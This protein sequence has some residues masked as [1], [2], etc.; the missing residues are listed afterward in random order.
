MPIVD[1]FEATHEIRHNA[2]CVVRPVI[3]AMTA[4]ALEGERE[5][6]LQ[7]GM[8]DY[9][10]K[11]VKIEMLAQT[12]KKWLPA[13]TL[14]PQTG[15][16]PLFTRRAPRAAFDSRDLRDSENDSV[17]HELLDGF[18]DLQ[19]PNEPN[20][21]TELIDLFVEDADKRIEAIKQAAERNDW[22]T[23]KEQAHGLKGSSGNIGANRIHELSNRLTEIAN[24][25]SAPKS[26]ATQLSGKRMERLVADLRAEFEKV[27]RILTARRV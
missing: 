8:D 26:A 1:G 3:V 2:A 10:S 9:V 23:I 22:H 19:Q 11:P 13:A 6:C 4:H 25:N 16:L 20:I 21:V 5:K 18:K 12:L 27:R 7:A 15:E 17:N 14:A 24:E